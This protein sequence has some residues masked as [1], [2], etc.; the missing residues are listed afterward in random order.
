MKFIYLLPLAL[1]PL[2]LIGCHSKPE[3][4]HYAHHQTEYFE[5]LKHNKVKSD[6]M[7][8]WKNI[9]PGMSGYNEEL[10]THPDDPNVILM[11]PDM[12]VAYGSWDQSV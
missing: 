2:G 12:H 3:P 5:Q 7:V 6:D 4:S 10:W 1:I 9:G 8:N 11:G